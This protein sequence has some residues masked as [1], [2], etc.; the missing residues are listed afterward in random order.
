MFRISALSIIV[1]LII[2]TSAPAVRADES[3]VSFWLPGQYASMAAV[4]ASPGFTLTTTFYYYQGHAG[5]SDT[6]AR[7]H[8]L[9]SNLDASTPLLFVTPSWAPDFKILGGQPSFSLS[10]VGGYQDVSA[11]AT[12]FPSG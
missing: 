10:V 2:M 9:E 6:L 7:E 5:G 4:P 8:I 3:G 12:L 11:D 1:A